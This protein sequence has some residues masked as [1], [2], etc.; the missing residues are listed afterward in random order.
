M[1][2]EDEFQNFTLF[3][4]LSQVA[5]WE[6][7]SQTF[8]GKENPHEVVMVAMAWVSPLWAAL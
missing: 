4:V 7:N 2:V 8:L 1:A 5:K 6:L 3:I